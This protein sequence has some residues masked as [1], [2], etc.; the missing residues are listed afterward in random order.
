MR[1]RWHT[2]SA[3]WIIHRITGVLLTLYIFLHLYVLS[4][5]KDPRKY[6]SLMEAMDNPLIKTGEAML[7][8]LIIAHALNGVRLTLLDC[9]VAS[10]Y[11]KR[12][13]C[14]AAVLAGIIFL[15]G[16]FPIIGGGH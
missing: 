15:A 1:N 7:L 16:V 3:A 12:L 11:H 2:G 4:S 14:S 10:K 9:G 13:F 8:L 6:E 5:L